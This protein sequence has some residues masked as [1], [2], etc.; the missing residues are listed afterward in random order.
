MIATQRDTSQAAAASIQPMAI[1]LRAKVFAHI[2]GCAEKGATCAEI[3]TALGMS[4]QTA[5]ARLVELERR[6]MVQ[7]LGERRPTATGRKAVVWY[8]ATLEAK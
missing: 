2:S 5:S 8:S 3:E 1:D 4:H 7:D 6:G